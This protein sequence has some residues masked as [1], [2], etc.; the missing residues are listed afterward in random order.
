MYFPIVSLKN[1]TTIRR[2]TRRME[3]DPMV[4]REL[5]REIAQKPKLQKQILATLSR[6]PAELRKVILELVTTL[7]VRRTILRLA[8]QRT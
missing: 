4:R 7:H 2:I 3:Q 6:H 5:F 8:N 1:P